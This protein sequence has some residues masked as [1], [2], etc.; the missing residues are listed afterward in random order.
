VTIFKMALGAAAICSV[1]S[2]SVSPPKPPEK[3]PDAFAD[4][5]LSEEPVAP[6][7]DRLPLAES[8]VTLPAPIE[9]ATAAD[10]EQSRAETP[11]E[12]NKPARARNKPARERNICTRHGMHKQV[13][14]GGRSWRCR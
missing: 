2:I 13:T 4:R 7:A 5:W 8:A 3:V 10:I 1:M 6:K 11:G 9:L 14:R 12:R